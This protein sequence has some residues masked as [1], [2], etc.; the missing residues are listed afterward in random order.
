LET[1]L[2]YKAFLTN[3]I[4]LDGTV[5]SGGLLQSYVRGTTTPLPLYSDLGVTPLT[6]PVV[7][8]SLGQLTVMYNDALQY[9]WQAKTAD[10]TATLWEATVTGGVVSYTYLND[11]LIQQFEENATGDGTETEYTINDVVLTSSYQLVV[12]IDG[13][14]QPTTTYSVGNNG[15]DTTVTFTTAPPNGSA[16]YMRSMA[17]QGLTGPAGTPADMDSYTTLSGGDGT[18]THWVR[19]SGSLNR[20]VTTNNTPV[21]ATSSTT[22]RTLAARFAEVFNVKDYG[23][24]GDGSTNDTTAIQAA[25]TACRTAGGGI[26]FF[27]AGNYLVTLNIKVGS[28]TTV[29]GVGTASRIF[30]T[31]ATFT[32]VNTGTDST[33][34][35]QIIK[36]HNHSASSITDSDITVEDI[37][38]DYTDVVVSGG[39]AHCV[40]MRYAERINIRRVYGTK[41]E[42]TTMLRAC[43]DAIV[44]SCNAYDQLNCYYD[45]YEGGSNLTVQNCTGR[46]PPGNYISQGIQFNGGGATMYRPKAIGNQLYGVRGATGQSTAIAMSGLTGDDCEDAL[47]MGNHIEDSDIGLVMADGG[48]WGL[49]I[50]DTFKNVDQ[51]PI[52]LQNGSP[53]HKY[54]RVLYPHLID[55]DHSVASQAMIS[56]AGEGHEVRGVQVTNTDGVANY[57]CI[58]WFTADAT[59]CFLEILRAPTGS[60]SRVLTDGTN[61]RYIDHDPSTGKETRNYALGLTSVSL[62]NTGLKI[63][64]TN[65]SHDLSIVPGSNI[66]ADRTLTIVT[67]DANRSLTLN[68]DVELGGAWASYTPTATAQTGSFTTLGTVSGRYQQVGKTVHFYVSVAITTNGT[69]ADFV[70][71]TLP[72]AA[73]SANAGNA[74]GREPSTGTLLFGTLVNTSDVWVSTPSGTYPGGDGRTIQ[75]AGVYEA[76]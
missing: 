46:N 19:T 12:S 72:V 31:Q 17:A 43:R 22:A 71:V 75:V 6:N 37:K 58:A 7:A 56:I 25:A 38:I 26:L 21:T 47:S 60:S 48:G 2:A 34:T 65:A 29:R 24:T 61:C 44:D 18:E 68:A 49:S 32:G 8:D 51:L 1:A 70:K 23:A 73:R 14:I 64:D 40:S 74:S 35:C 3:L 27:P 50:G 28:N 52:Y 59:D 9:S 13:L 39:G 10:N 15:T 30:A 36:N 11:G 76:A 63:R 53:D 69:A 33:T 16:I 45:A 41:G 66:T 5:E 20:K 42:N 67:G 57:A 4:G 54:C 62:D 55:C